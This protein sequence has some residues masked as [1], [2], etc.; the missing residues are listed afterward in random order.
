MTAPGQLKPEEREKLKELA[1]AV[2]PDGCI[3]NIGVEHGASIACFRAGNPTCHIIGIDIDLTTLDTETYLACEPLLVDG[4][5]GLQA[6]MRKVGDLVN[7]FGYSDWVQLLFIDGDHSYEGVLKDIEF[8]KYIT[9]PGVGIA[10]FHD[11]YAWGD[12]DKPAS[13]PWVAG[14]H[15]AV[16]EWFASTASW[17]EVDKAGTMRIFKRLA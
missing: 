5:S 2:P 8:C 14:V 16:D 11:Y 1:E 6:T 7:T 15:Q 4:D 12:N 9:E 10:V 3:I 13:D 17:E